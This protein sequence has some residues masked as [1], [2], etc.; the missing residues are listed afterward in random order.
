MKV[1]KLRIENYLTVDNM[2]M[3]LKGVK[4]FVGENA[5]GKTNIITAVQDILSGVQDVRKIKDGKDKALI[6]IEE[7]VDNEVVKQVS[8]TITEKG[9]YLKGK[10]LA[11]GETPISY[12]SKLFDKFA[13]NPIN[14]VTGNPVDYLKKHLPVKA[15]EG[16]VL[17]GTPEKFNIENNAFEEC[18]RVADYIAVVR[19]EKGK[20]LKHEEE[21]VSEIEKTVQVISAPA[22]SIEELK[23]LRADKEAQLQKIS[24]NVNVQKEIEAKLNGIQAEQKMATEKI[25]RIEGYMENIAQIKKTVHDKATEAEARAKEDYE[26]KIAEINKTREVEI[27]KI[28]HNIALGEEQKKSAKQ[29]IASLEEKKLQLTKELSTLPTVSEEQLRAEIENIKNKAKQHYD[30]EKNE[31]RKKQVTERIAKKNEIDAAHKKL[32]TYYKYYAYELPKL[33]IDR[34]KLPVEGLEFKDNELYVKGRHIDRLSTAEKVL[35]GLGLAIELA[36]QKGHI[37]LC[38]DG[39]EVLDDANKML[40]MEQ[41]AKSGLCIMYTRHGK[42]EFSHEVEVKKG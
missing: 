31:E 21:V 10:G 23:T 37:T 1:Y 38:I 20:D 3:E 28:D 4:G 42:P 30:F 17:D 27:E 7:I 39:I 29:S 13:I 8:R 26:R 15:N 5:Q 9:E 32:D 2:E 33:L 40:F 18:Q 6:Q 19:K 16:D 41:A 14:L 12:L 36:K 35:T 25:S 11:M 34:C 22:E 24:N